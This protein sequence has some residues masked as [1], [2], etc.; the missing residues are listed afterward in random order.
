[1]NYS[2]PSI[3]GIIKVQFETSS[4]AKLDNKVDSFNDTVCKEFDWRKGVYR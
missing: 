1:M 2:F 3:P 4:G